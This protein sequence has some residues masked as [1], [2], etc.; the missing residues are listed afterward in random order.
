MSNQAVFPNNT[1]TRPHCVGDQLSVLDVISQ[2][3]PRNYK[4][5]PGST[6]GRYS[7]QCP[8]HDDRQHPDY[9]GS[10]LVDESEQVFK[11]FGCDASGNAYQLQKILG[12]GF[13]IPPRTTP[14]PEPKKSKPNREDYPKL[15]G[16]TIDQLAEKKGLDAD[17]LRRDLDWQDTPYPPNGKNTI[18]A[19]RIP[20]PDEHGC[21][22]QVRYRVGLDSDRDRFRWEKGA[23]MRPLGLD[24][25]AYLKEQDMVIF[26]EGGTDYATGTQHGYPF[27]GIPGATNWKTAWAHHYK[28]LSQHFVWKEP[29]KGGEAFV[30]KLVES[31]PKLL[32]IEAPPGAKDPTELALQTGPEAFREMFDD[33]LEEAYQ[34]RFVADTVTDKKDL[35]RISDKAKDWQEKSP[36]WAEAKT[37]FP[38][39]SHVKPRMKGCLL[40]SERDRKGLAVDLFSNTWRNPANAQHKRQKLYL[41]ILPKING[42]QVYQRRVPIDDWD[43]TVHRS[44]SKALQRAVSDK[45]GWMWINNALAHGYYIY[46]TSA[47]GLAG[48]EPVEDVRPVLLNALKAIHPPE[49]D[50]G[51]GR[52]RPYGGS[53]NWIGKAEDSGEGDAG[54]WEIVAVGHK[55]TDFTLLE[56]E[57]GVAEI[58]TEF[59]RP[60][61]RGQSYEGLSMRHTSKEAFVAFAARFPEQ[62]VLTRA[63]FADREECR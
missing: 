44:I 54:R 24:R 6:R 14:R 39:P 29:G 8:L 63:A 61:W 45:Q 4:V 22:V 31:F 34:E 36:L 32:V 26:V 53:R 60:Y 13:D 23:K 47:P 48:F 38:I 5:L 35:Y 3:S 49:R 62:Y 41:N 25:L 21:D 56:A 30:A 16:V 27:Q 52:F 42:P 43:K 58:A 1:T 15:Q 19:I 10:F 11:C 17:F 18:P 9:S 33:L 46:L 50:E 37:L 51:E 7:M 40:W 12:G 2:H 59:E 57:C 28:D 20:Y 55:P